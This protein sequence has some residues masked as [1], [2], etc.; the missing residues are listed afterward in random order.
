MRSIGRRIQNQLRTEF[1]DLVKQHTDAR[2]SLG[3]VRD[4]LSDIVRLAK[5]TPT[6]NGENEAWKSILRRAEV[7]VVS[8]CMC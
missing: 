7:N 4:V 8:L 5:N 2:E 3:K 1:R 6:N